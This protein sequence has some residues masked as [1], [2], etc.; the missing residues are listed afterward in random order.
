ME[1]QIEQYDFLFGLLLA[2]LLLRHSDN[3]SKALQHKSLSAAEANI[4][5]N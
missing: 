2:S 5:Q 3:L 4:L 1:A